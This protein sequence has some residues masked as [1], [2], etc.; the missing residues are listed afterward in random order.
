M[1]N[2][3]AYLKNRYI[4]TENLPRLELLKHGELQTSDSPVQ[5]MQR[6]A[7]RRCGAGMW[8]PSVQQVA[9]ELRHFCSLW[10]R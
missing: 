5:A 8:G 1:I 9:L 2:I 6:I 7:L 10:P 4:E 3:S